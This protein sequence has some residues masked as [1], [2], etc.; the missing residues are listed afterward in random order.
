MREISKARKKF[1][2]KM[3]IASFRLL[4]GSLFTIGPKKKR[5]CDRRW[6]EVAEGLCP[7]RG[8]DIYGTRHSGSGSSVLT[9]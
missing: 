9:L 3:L 5:C 8:F 2:E 7:V 4:D 1:S 6:M